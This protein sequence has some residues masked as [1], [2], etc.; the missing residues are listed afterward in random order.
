[1]VKSGLYSKGIAKRAH[2][3]KA[4][5]VVLGR[6][7]QAGA[8]LRAI[9]REAGVSLAGLMHYFDS[10]DHLLT[11]ILRQYDAE[12]ERLYREAGHADPGELLA[13]AMTL[14]EAE[15]ARPRLY[16][17]LTVE[18][19]N[20]PKHP[21]SAYLAE[22]YKRILAGIGDYIRD[23]QELGSIHPAIDADYVASAVFAAAEGIQMQWLH[24]PTVDQGAH[25][26]RVWRAL[27]QP[28]AATTSS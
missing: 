21:A 8:S 14:N 11:E 18:A 28:P 9:A 15:P 1:V 2:I 27:L 4:A 7:G 23:Q 22:R 20:S 12:W 17:Y 6:E 3:L 13:Q 19:A 26:R 25:V 24:D 16:L 10:R 5:L